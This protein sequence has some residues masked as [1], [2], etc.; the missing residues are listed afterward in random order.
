MNYVCTGNAKS[1]STSTSN[2]V[3]LSLEPQNGGKECF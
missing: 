2:I 3:D 1:A